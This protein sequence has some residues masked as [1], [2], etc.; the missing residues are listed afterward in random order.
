MTEEMAKLALQ[1]LQRVQLTGQEVEAYMAVQQ[2]VIN[3]INQ[4]EPDESDSS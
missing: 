2:A 4:P 1:F 3:S